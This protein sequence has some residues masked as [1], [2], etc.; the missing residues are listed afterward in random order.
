MDSVGIYRT[1]GSQTRIQEL[2]R[3]FNRGDRVRLNDY[4]VPTVA[5]VMKLF[6]RELP[7]KLIPEEILPDLEEAI[8]MNIYLRETFFAFFNQPADRSIVRCI[9]EI[10]TLI[11]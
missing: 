4:D 11:K 3:H 6:I 10:Y 1:S 2:K 8:G 5:D 9:N 7:E